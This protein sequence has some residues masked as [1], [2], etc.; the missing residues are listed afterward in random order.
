MENLD[1]YILAYGKYSSDFC[2]SSISDDV[3]LCV[4]YYRDGWM[5]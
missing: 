3:R 1:E 5:R 2:S 4:L